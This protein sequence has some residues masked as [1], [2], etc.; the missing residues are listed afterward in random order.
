MS[1]SQ[2]GFKPQTNPKCTS[3]P[4]KDQG[5]LDI[6]CQFQWET[7]GKTYGRWFSHSGPCGE[8]LLRSSVPETRKTC[9]IPWGAQQPRTMQS[10]FRK[11]LP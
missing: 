3:Q 11:Y 4:P 10:Q 2:K 7:Q 5:K 9:H 1:K 8:Y 6:C